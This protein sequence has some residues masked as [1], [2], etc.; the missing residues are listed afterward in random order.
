MEQKKKFHSQVIIPIATAA[1]AL[2]FIIVGMTE[3]GFWKGQPTPGFFPII[4]AVALLI[5]SVISILQLLTGKGLTPVK[6]NM[7]EMSVILGGGAV[8][9][10]TFLIGL[11]LSCFLY[12]FLWLH[13]MEHA[14]IKHIIIIELV[15][16]FIIIGVF[17]MWLQ[18]RFPTG[19]V[20]SMLGL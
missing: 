1:V 19:I 15:I 8:I 20:G 4:I 5:T 13:F 3:Y 17:T 18:V 11:P 2:V 6:Y 12:I 14:P 10:C 7:Q 16:A 9:L